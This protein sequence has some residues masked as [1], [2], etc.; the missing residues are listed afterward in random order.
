M[1][2]E[3]KIVTRNLV[4]NNSDSVKYYQQQYFNSLN[5]IDSIKNIPGTKAWI[6]YKVRP[7]DNLSRIAIFFYNDISKASKIASD[8]KL[9]NMNLITTNQILKIEINE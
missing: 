5:K 1:K 9:K 8:N 3:R 2:I 6:T 7:G 4:N